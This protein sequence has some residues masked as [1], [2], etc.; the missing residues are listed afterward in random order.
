MIAYALRLNKQKYIAS[1]QPKRNLLTLYIICLF[2][3]VHVMVI[4]SFYYGIIFIHAYT[5]SIIL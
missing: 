5:W 2:M 4:I 3:A 1:I